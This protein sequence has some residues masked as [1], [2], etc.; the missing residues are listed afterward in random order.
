MN[1]HDAYATPSARM[2]MA[3]FTKKG[4]QRRPSLVLFSNPSVAFRALE[5]ALDP[6]F[7]LDA[8]GRV[9]AVG[10]EALDIHERHHLLRRIVLGAADRRV[11]DRLVPV[12]ELHADAP[13]RRFPFRVLQRGGDLL[14]GRLLAAVGG[15]RL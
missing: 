15:H 4:G 2:V 7:A 1:S 3:V 14:P 10:V 13:G 8:G 11:L 6:V 9:D 12:A 5:A